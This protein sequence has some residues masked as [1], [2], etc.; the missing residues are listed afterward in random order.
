MFL[1][2]YAFACSGKLHKYLP[3]YPQSD[4]ELHP[5]LF[6]EMPEP[7]NTGAITGC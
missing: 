7:S 6:P 3:V 1:V 2:L 4:I 5:L